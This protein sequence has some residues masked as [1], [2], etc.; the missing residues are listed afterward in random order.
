MWP[1]RGLRRRGS[2]P[3]DLYLVGEK[4]T[5]WR[6]KGGAWSLVL[7]AP[8][9]AK[10]LTVSG[11]GAKEVYAVGGAVV[12]RSSGDGFSELNIDLTNLVNGVACGP[13]GSALLVGDGGQKQRLVSG[14]W[15]DEFVIEPYDDLH[16]AWSDG[17][18]S[19][20][21]VGG[22]FHGPKA[23]GVRRKGVVARYGPGTVPGDVQ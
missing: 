1:V 13:S 12:L 18:G 7:P 15:I 17:T 22:D 10:L 16:A 2:A 21:A 4:G 14:A 8:A 23:A 9:S 11:C 20:W 19:F 5:I 3:D 6:K